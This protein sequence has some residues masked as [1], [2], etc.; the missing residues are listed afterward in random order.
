[1]RVLVAVDGSS[2][3]LQAARLVRTLDW[4]DGTVV[5]LLGVVDPGAWIPPGP[6]V[7]GSGGLIR[8]DQIGT[9][10]AEHQ[11]AIAAE[12]PRA[13]LDV[14]NTLLEGRPADAII[15]EARR[16]DVDLIV[17]GSRGHGRLT[18]LL[19]GSVSAAV[20]DRAPCSVLVARTDEVTRALLAIDGSRSARSA[21]RIAATWSPFAA[22]PIAVVTVAE[23][24]RPWTR[25]INP[26]FVTRA[27]RTAEHLA[28]N[29]S[30][31][32]TQI[33][34]EVVEGLRQAGRSATAHVRE[35]DV[36][37]EVI[38]AAGEH[39][40]DLVMVGCRGRSRMRTFLL[41]SVARDVLLASDAS[42]MVVRAE[43]VASPRR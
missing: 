21:A 9:Y 40:A 30:S 4:P 17:V 32:A 35:G 18:S 37:S 6:G 7:P 19:L 10:L 23:P 24:V 20:V 33:A 11:L 8:E 13:D 5:T 41:G 16:L 14:E 29:A 25:A 3:S 1:M 28:R 36:A 27:R 38:A 26:A 12:L 2:G 34:E 43:R 39:D 42:V 22:V 31:E 15:A